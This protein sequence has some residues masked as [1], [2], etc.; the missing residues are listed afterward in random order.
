MIV[1]FTA[2]PSV[3]RTLE[4]S[5]LVRGAVTRATRTR[6]DGGGKGVNVTR[7]LAA[8]GYPSIAVLPSGGAGRLVR[9][10]DRG[11]ARAGRPGSGR[12]RRPRTVGYIRRGS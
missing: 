6:V 4:I 2:N 1:T 3:D 7:A 10:L 11:A 9:K 8:N 5:T 12:H